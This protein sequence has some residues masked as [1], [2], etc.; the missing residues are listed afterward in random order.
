MVD[1]LITVTK[2]K[3]KIKSKQYKNFTLLFQYN[4]KAYKHIPK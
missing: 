4:N 1:K 3:K 2:I